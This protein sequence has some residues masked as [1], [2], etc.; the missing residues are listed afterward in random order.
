MKLNIMDTMR[1][2]QKVN[3]PRKIGLHDCFH[4][5][6]TMARKSSLYQDLATHARFMI[7]HNLAKNKRAFSDGEIV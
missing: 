7:V 6:Q 3:D 5:Q 2:C 1:T 4:K